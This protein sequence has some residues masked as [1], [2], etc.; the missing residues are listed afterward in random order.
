MT[1]SHRSRVLHLYRTLLC[2]AARFPSIKKKS[3]I[4]DIRAEFRE[5][6][7][8]PANDPRVAR[9]VTAAEHGLKTMRKYTRLDAGAT[10]WTVDLEEDP[11]GVGSVEAGQRRADEFE[12]EP[13]APT[14]TRLA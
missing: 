6:A 9:S 8:L 2:E 5:G 1:S 12:A 4:E 3:L 13:M 11:F 7:N 14:P 10:A